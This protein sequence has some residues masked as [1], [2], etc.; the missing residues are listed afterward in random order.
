TTHNTLI[1]VA[2]TVIPILILVVIAIPSFRLLYL[3]RDIP[4]GDMTIKVI[5]NPSWNWTYEYPDLGLDDDGALRLRLDERNIGLWFVERMV[6]WR[7]RVLRMPWGD[8]RSSCGHDEGSWERSLRCSSEG[9]PRSI[10]SASENTALEF[11]RDR[12]IYHR[13]CRF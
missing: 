4:A 3:Q 10:A 1:E 2:W 6:A 7:S 12:D 9:E 5:G 13:G 8:H 11:I